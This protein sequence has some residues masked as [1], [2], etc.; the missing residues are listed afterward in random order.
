MLGIAQRCRLGVNSMF[1]LADIRG[2]QNAQPLGVCGHDSVLDSV[3]YHLHEVSG[4]VRTAV[5]V[6]FFG[7][8]FRLLATRSA[9]YVTHSRCERLE[10][11]IEMTDHVRLAADHHAVA[12]LQSPHTAA[13]AYIDIV[14]A[15]RRQ[16]A[17]APN[18]V[19]VI[20]IP[21]VNEDV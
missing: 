13:R 4:P 10:D 8:T 16:L 18:V 2:T 3:V 9:R 5:Q 7:G 12:S 1:L 19:D 11:G 6:A 21:A 17:R 14:N 15:L 20:R